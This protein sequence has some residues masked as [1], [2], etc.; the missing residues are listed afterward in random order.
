MPRLFL[1]IDLPADIKSELI[2]LPPSADG[3]RPVKA[4][5]LH[6]TLHFLGEW[7]LS[8]VLAALQPVRSASF[9]MMLEGV[10]EF[11]QR[12]RSVILWAGM[13]MTPELRQLHAELASALTAIGYEP[14]SRPYSPHITLARGRPETPRSAVADF[15]RDHSTWKTREFPVADYRLISSALTPSGSVYRCERVFP[16]DHFPQTSDRPG[17]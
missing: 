8:P 11:R 14:E 2:R 10:G 4:D 5:Q 12:D 7:E 13:R 3:L 1:A 17:N 15:L 9:R 16:L 6:L